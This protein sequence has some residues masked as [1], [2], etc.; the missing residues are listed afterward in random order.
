MTQKILFGIPP[1]AHV[2]LAQDELEG[3]RKIGY[4]CISIAYGRNN[5]NISKINKFFGVVTNAFKIVFK[6]YNFKPHTLYLNS[7]FEPVACARDFITI[8]IIRCLY[9]FKLQVIIKTHGSDLSVLDN[10][11]F[12]FK[13][14]VLPYLAKYV[15][16]WL[17]LSKEE[18]TIT[19]SKNPQLGKRIYVTSNIVE[20]SRS[21]KSAAFKA[22]YNLPSDKFLFLF[23]GRIVDEKGVFS[24][25]RSIPNL[26]FKD[27][28]KFVFVGDGPDFLALQEEAKLLHLTNCVVF[29]GFIEDEECDHFYA[30]VDALVFPTYFNEG[31]PMALFKSVAA[32]LP[33]ITT[34]I[35]AAKD[36]LSEPENVL[37]VDGTSASSV[38]KAIDQ[39]YNDETLRNTMSKNNK[40]VSRNFVGERVCKQM[41]EVFFKN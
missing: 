36:H 2:T 35:R 39:L 13:K 41:E 31:F 14:I 16:K 15:D 21:I 28:C 25:L 26:T 8:L 3:F 10:N 33:I 11:S 4:N 7:R 19:E 24:I 18:K 12:G 27:E 6:L 1:K 37:W 30:N 38:T 22:K 20:P 29:T 17:F 23:V 9:V 32:G 5:Q 40:L 34:P